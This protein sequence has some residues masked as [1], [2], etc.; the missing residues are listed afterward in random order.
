[1]KWEMKNVMMETQSEETDDLLTD[2]LLKL[3]MSVLEE[4]L[5][6]MMSAHYVH[7]VCTQTMQQTQKTESLVAAMDL[8]SQRQRNVMMEMTMMVTD[9]QTIVLR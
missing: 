1:M 7:L 4:V 6:Q 3:A 5:D 8:K 2:V 9:A